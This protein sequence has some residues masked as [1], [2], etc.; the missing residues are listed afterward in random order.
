MPQYA[1]R[2][3][4]LAVALSVV[5][6]VGCQPSTAAA[7]RKAPARGRQAAAPLSASA[8]TDTARLLAGLPTDPSG[9]LGAVAAKP[10]WQA[11][12]KEFDN[13]WTQATKERFAEMTAW[14]DKEL[15]PATGTCSTLMYPFSGPDGSG[16]RPASILAVSVSPSAEE[17]AT[18]P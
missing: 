11:W 15:A 1:L 10:A 4:T 7:R 16:G 5:G 13:Q 18:V 2:F 12:Q 6:A 3:V 9:P 8:L 14:R 17:G